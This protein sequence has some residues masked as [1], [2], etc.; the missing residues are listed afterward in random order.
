MR[1]E[2]SKLTDQG[3]VILGVVGDSRQAMAGYLEKQPLPFTM[4]IDEDREVMK[5]FEVFNRLSWE[6]YRMAHPSAFLIDPEG[7]IRYSFVASHQW[8]WPRTQLLEG[9][10]QQDALPE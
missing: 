10:A 8:D 3:A 5:A 4:L 7:Q 2:S 9:V 1:S 6:G